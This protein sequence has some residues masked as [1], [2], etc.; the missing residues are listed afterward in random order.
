MGLL[1]RGLEAYLASSPNYN[2]PMYR[3]LVHEI[4][5]TFRNISE[6]VL[7]IQEKLQTN[8]GLPE[9]AKFISKVQEEEKKKLEVVSINIYFRFQCTT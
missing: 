4:T 6:E 1:Y 7:C 8:H 9:V 3:Q 2:F 5:Q